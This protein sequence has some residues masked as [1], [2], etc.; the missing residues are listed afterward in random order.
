MG[1]ADH[2]D[3]EALIGQGLPEGKSSE[4]GQGIAAQLDRR[5][6]VAPLDRQDGAAA[7]H[8]RTPQAGVRLAVELRRPLQLDLLPTRHSGRAA[9]SWAASSRMG[10]ASPD[11]DMFRYR[12]A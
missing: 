6:R 2:L 1:V 8:P 9:G 5:L 3:A 10:S 12:L 11:M 7:K 4:V